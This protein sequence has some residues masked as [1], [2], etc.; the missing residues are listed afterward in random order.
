MDRL[1]AGKILFFHCREGSLTKGEICDFFNRT[2]TSVPFRIEPDELCRLGTIPY[3]RGIGRDGDMHTY[4][5]FD[6]DPYESAPVGGEKGSSD[7]STDVPARFHEIRK[8]DR[9]LQD[10]DVSVEVSGKHKL[11]RYFRG[12]RA[13]LNKL[14]SESRYLVVF[15]LEGEMGEDGVATLAND[16]NK[17]VGRGMKDGE[18]SDSDV[19]VLGQIGKKYQASGDFERYDAFAVKVG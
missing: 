15:S 7:I 12:D 14:D 10:A 17:S 3:S 1:P 9:G 13:G 18:Y 2:C 16:L 11:E 8:K 5:G 19:I 6:L 4:Y